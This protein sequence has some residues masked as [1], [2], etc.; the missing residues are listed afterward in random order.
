MSNLFQLW[1]SYKN[2]GEHFC[3]IF[4]Y[5]VISMR[6]RFSFIFNVFHYKKSG[7]K[8]MKIWN[9]VFPQIMGFFFQ[10]DVYKY[11]YIFVYFIFADQDFFQFNFFI[12]RFF[13]ILRL[14]KKNILYLNIQIVNIRTN[15]LNSFYFLPTKIDFVNH[16]T[17]II[18]WHEY[19]TIH[20]SFIS[21][22]NIRYRTA[23]FTCIKVNIWHTLKYIQ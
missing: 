17:H 6:K 4:S 5:N 2:V 13:S 21:C 9:W 11:I 22:C 14:K 1:R 8:N 23:I 15:I 12:S 16:I 18:S 7:V 3:D 10:I 20:H 19:S